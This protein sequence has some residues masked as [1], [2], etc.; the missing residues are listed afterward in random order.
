MIELPLN[1]DDLQFLWPLRY[2]V[3]I[4]ELSNSASEEVVGPRALVFIRYA[5]CMYLQF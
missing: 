2:W 1:F 5:L 3:P 4:D